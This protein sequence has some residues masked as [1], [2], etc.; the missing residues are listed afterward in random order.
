MARPGARSVVGLA[1]IAG[2]LF[3]FADGL[4]ETVRVPYCDE[5]ISR[6]GDQV[7]PDCKEGAE[8]AF[9]EL[10]GGAFVVAAGMVLGQT[11]F[12][13]SL[14]FG[15]LSIAAAVILWGEG[16]TRAKAFAVLIVVIGGITALAIARGARKRRRIREHGLALQGRVHTISSLNSQNFRGERGYR[17]QVAIQRPGAAHPELIRI[18]HDYPIDQVPRNGE[19]VNLRV[20]GKK[21]IIDA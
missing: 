21:A 7:G 8:V 3:L 6:S 5:R 14:G 13:T 11:G 15:G 16:S 10:I 20:L 12:F 17:M 1:L 18:D 9:V 19:V 4:Y 2:G